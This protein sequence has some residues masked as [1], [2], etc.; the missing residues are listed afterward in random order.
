MDTASAS[1]GNKPLKQT[2]GPLDGVSPGPGYYQLPVV[3]E[4]KI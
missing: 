1:F 4:I 2:E 3:M